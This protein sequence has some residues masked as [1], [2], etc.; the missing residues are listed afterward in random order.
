MMQVNRVLLGMVVSTI[1]LSA[2]VFAQ[3]SEPET[4]TA[5]V[6]RGLFG[7]TAADERHP[8]VVNFTLL[9]YAAADDNSRFASAS[10]VADEALQ[11]RRIYE[12]AQA[13]LGFLRRRPRSVLRVDG[14]SALRYY[15]D[16]NRVAT[17]KHSGS[18]GLEYVLSHRAK[19]QLAQSA[20][21]SPYY[22][23]V[24]GR[25]LGA[26][27]APDVAPATG[28]YSVARQKQMVYGSSAVLSYTAGTHSALTVGYAGQHTDFFDSQD[29][30]SQRAA[31]RYTHEVA[32][33]IGLR[34]GYGF[35]VDSFGGSTS[36]HN[37]DLDFGIDYGRALAISSRTVLGFT[38]GTT[39]VATSGG[40]QVQVIGSA[41]LRHQLSRSTRWNA[42]VAYDR[43]LQV[44][45]SVP[46]PFIADTVTAG[47]NGYISRRI[48]LRVLPSFAT[49][50][51]VGDD[52]L[53]YHSFLE[54]TRLDMAISRNWAAYVEHF[55]YRYQFPATATLPAV[56]SAGLNRQGLRVGLSLWTPIAR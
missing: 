10:D 3:S 28:D 35:G 8:P 33:G 56:L 1:G 48:S 24:L 49:G 20:S 19:V 12:G 31:A 43:G 17:Q 25:P 47:I 32:A 53:R 38:S 13:G 27:N 44:I 9:A 37:H 42:Q 4:P 50:V 52:Q 11:S 34:L 46:R 21:F 26:L 23:L 7:P 29:F 30:H 36:T 5:H 45:E 54:Q 16:L 15:S 41:Q 22:Q 51:D 14:S 39:M 40:R 18:I 55:Y 6:F 2:P